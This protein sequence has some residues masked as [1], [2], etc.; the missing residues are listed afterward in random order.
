[1]GKLRVAGFTALPE[2]IPQDVVE[3]APPPPQLSNMVLTGPDGDKHVCV[4]D[5][6]TKQWYHHPV[7]GGRFRAFIDDFHEE[8]SPASL[9]GVIAFAM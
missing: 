3:T 4:P 8:Q 7:F 1:M 2:Q 9:C 5:A 6:L